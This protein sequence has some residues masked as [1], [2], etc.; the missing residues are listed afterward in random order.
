MRKFWRYY[1]LA[2]LVILQCVPW[3][4]ASALTRGAAANDFTPYITGLSLPSDLSDSEL[5]YIKNYLSEIVEEPYDYPNQPIQ[6]VDTNTTAFIGTAS[7]GPVL[8]PTPVDNWDEYI[9]IFGN[10]DSNSCL[11][12][13]VYCYFLNGGQ[14]AYIVRVVQVSPVVNNKIISRY[15]AS[16]GNT[17]NSASILNYTTALSALEKVD[18]VSLV[19]IPG[20]TDQAAQSAL[21][22]H[23]EKMKYRFAILDSID[24]AGVSGSGSVQEQSNKLTS[25]GG[26]AALYY[27][28]IKIRNPITQT[29][30]CVPPSGAVAGL[31]AQND[32]ERGVWKAPANMPVIGVVGLARSVDDNEQNALNSSGVNAIRSFPGRGYLVWGARTLA[33]NSAA[34]EWKYINVRRLA[35]FAEESISSGTQ[36]AQFEPNNEALWAEVS[37]SAYNFLYQLWTNGA[38]QGSYPDDAF[39]VKC[40]RTTMTQ[41]DIDNQ[42]LVCLVGIAATRPDEFTIFYISHQVQ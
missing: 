10:F 32:L 13:A 14:K 17:S 33:M 41:Y 34:S 19:A 39:F 4:S 7:Q 3:G 40:D 1:L 2:V 23:C 22:R 24:G 30:I 31:Y 28:W 12:Q 35:S 16:W 26:F 6:E 38:L 42:R 15:T 21:I 29:E 11:S 8:Q 5:D 37:N 18:G 25:S 20:Q 9:D 36:W 27:P